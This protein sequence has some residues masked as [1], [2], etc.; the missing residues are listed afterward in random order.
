MLAE[1][2][3]PAFSIQPKINKH[4]KVAF[5]HMKEQTIQR[6]PFLARLKQMFYIYV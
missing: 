3:R 5:N 6:K 2:C 4:F 1:K